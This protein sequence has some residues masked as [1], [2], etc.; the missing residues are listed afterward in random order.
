MFQLQSALYDEEGATRN[1]KLKNSL[2]ERFKGI[3]TSE[4]KEYN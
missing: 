3:K 2:I 1:I 4:V